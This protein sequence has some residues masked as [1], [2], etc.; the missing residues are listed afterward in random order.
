LVV[1]IDICSSVSLGFAHVYRP[2]CQ[3]ELA[4]TGMLPYPG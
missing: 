3:A 4:L 2:P 1:Y